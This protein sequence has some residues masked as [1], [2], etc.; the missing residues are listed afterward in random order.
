MTSREQLVRLVLGV[1]VLLC[2][3]GVTL[4]LG[5]VRLGPA[6]YLAV[7]RGG[8]QLTLVSL[9]LRGALG[10][11]AVVALA[12]V[13]MLGV[14]VRTAAGRLR[15]LEGAGRATLLACSSGAATALGVVFALGV[16]PFEP[17][18]VVA[19]GGI[20]IGSTMTGASL[21]GRRLLDGLR[22]QRAEVE[23]W[24]AL[25]ATSRQ[26]VVHI[27]RHAAGEALLPAIDQTRTTGL[28]T[29]PGAF[30]G[31]LLGGAD[32]TQAARFQLV[33]LASIMTSQ[34]VVAV[35]LVHQLGAPRQIPVDDSRPGSRRTS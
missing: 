10:R 15:G 22:S 19:L 24:L 13:V 6:P 30:I 14:A 33:V 11:P 32:P 8:L 35:L 17:R 31:A 29:L 23:G 1:A 12:L 4:R 34:A 7:L 18:Y 2:V 3:T 20:V 9:A 16:L 27:A 26:A 25:G 5:R 28:V 21:A